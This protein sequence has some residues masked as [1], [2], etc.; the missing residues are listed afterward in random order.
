MPD[1]S[2]GQHAI[3]TLRGWPC[4]LTRRLSLTTAPDPQFL[5]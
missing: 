3:L 1:L 2:V 5:M 4:S